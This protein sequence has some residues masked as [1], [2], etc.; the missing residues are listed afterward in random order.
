MGCEKEQLTDDLPRKINK[1]AKTYQLEDFFAFINFTL[2]TLLVL[3]H[4]CC[5]AETGRNKDSVFH[6]HFCTGFKFSTDS[7]IIA[8]NVIIFD[9]QGNNH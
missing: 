6:E 5:S 3:F 8:D 1:M 7:Q 9:Y 4:I 2:S